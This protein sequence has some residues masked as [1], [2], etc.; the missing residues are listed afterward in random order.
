MICPS[1]GLRD[2]DTPSGFCS[3]CVVDRAATAYAQKD[4][5]Q[6]ERRLQRWR[7]R[8]TRPD[9]HL[10]LLRQHRSRT[11]ARIRPTEPVSVFDPWG[12][13]IEGLD[14]C[15]LI[16]KSS[17]QHRTELEGIAEALR[18]L[19]WGPDDEGIRSVTRSR[20]RRQIPGQL[21]LWTEALEVAA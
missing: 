8:S 16:A 15:R 10:L 11:L 2:T 6:A 18:R 4:R 7:Q 20:R 1:C 12:L 14:R 9:A 13:A 21:M 5:D 3:D 19:A 17:P